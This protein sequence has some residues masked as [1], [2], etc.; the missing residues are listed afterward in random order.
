MNCS[1]PDLPVLQ[2]LPEFAQTQVHYFNDAIQPSLYHPFLYLPSIFLNIRVFSKELA[3]HIRW[4]KFWNF[5]FSIS[6]SNEYS[7]LISFRIDWFDVVAVQRDSQ[8]SSLAS[9]LEIINSSALAFLM[10]QLSHLY[11]TTG[12][13]ITLTRWTFISKL[14]YLLF[15]MSTFSSSSRS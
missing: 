1:L 15:N 6:P 14:M 7:G 9:Q 5:S 11:M 4:P 13:P 8:K 2:Y 10:V 12:K 3:L